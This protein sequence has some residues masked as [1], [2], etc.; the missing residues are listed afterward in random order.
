MARPRL[1]PLK[2]MARALPTLS[3]GTTRE[4]NGAMVVQSRPCARPPT[5]RAA[6]AAV[7]L[8][9]RPTRTLLSAKVRTS[10]TSRVFRGTL[11]SS[12]AAGITVTT[13]TAA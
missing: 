5:K 13:M 10:D 9:A 6:M 11:A 1:L 8:G 3:A 12:R 2:T 7:K 4:T